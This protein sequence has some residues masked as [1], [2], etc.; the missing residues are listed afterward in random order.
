MS[1]LCLL[2]FQG[3][4]CKIQL[5]RWGN[6]DLDELALLQDTLVVGYCS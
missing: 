1:S 2:E 6:K 5:L 4:Y 3:F